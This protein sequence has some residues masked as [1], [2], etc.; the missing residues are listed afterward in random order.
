VSLSIECE[1]EDRNL[2]AGSLR[3]YRVN[4]EN[5]IYIFWETGAIMTRRPNSQNPGNIGLCSRYIFNEFQGQTRRSSHLMMSR[6]CD[7]LC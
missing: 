5:Q 3:I 1:D 4:T 2:E 6:A 7:Q